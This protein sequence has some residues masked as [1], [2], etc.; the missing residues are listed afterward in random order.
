MELQSGESEIT[1]VET[2]G[3]LSH[4]SFLG[5]HKQNWLCKAGALYKAG[6]TVLNMKKQWQ[7]QF[8]LLQLHYK[9]VK[10]TVLR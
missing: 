7:C 4:S 10:A 6:F 9:I 3:K 1:V 2:V 5:N 8:R